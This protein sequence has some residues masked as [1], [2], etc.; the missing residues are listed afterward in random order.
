M[1]P[2][3]QFFSSISFIILCRD[4]GK[5]ELGLNSLCDNKSAFSAA[6]WNQYYCTKAIPAWTLGVKST[7]QLDGCY[8]RM[9][10]KVLN[11]H[12]NQHITNEQLYGKLFYKIRRRWPT[13]AE[14]CRRSEDELASKLVLWTPK[15]GQRKQ[16]KPAL[17]YRDVLAKYTRLPADQLDNCMQEWKVWRSIT[18]GAGRWLLALSQLSQSVPFSQIRNCIVCSKSDERN[19]AFT[20]RSLK[21]LYDAVVPGKCATFSL[22]MSICNLYNCCNHSLWM[23]STKYDSSIIFMTCIFQ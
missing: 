7:K 17:K 11:I 16:G 21:F 12:W 1:Q 3:D 5:R 19:Y 2:C 6:Q 8:T 14:H 15:H 4:I 9:L 22:I 18:A 10:R 20:I 13:F 23:G